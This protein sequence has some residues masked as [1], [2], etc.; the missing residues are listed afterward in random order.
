VTTSGEGLCWGY[1]G[2]GQTNVPTGK[3]WSSITSG[4][5]HSCGVTTSGEGLCWG[6]NHFGQT[7]VPGGKTWASFTAGL[8]DTCGVTTSGE[9]LCWGYNTDGRANVPT[10]KTWA[11]IT[12]GIDHSCG[13][14]TGGEGLCWGFDGHQDAYGYDYD[15]NGDFTGPNEYYVAAVPPD[16][17]LDVP[18]GKFDAVNAPS[19][20]TAPDAPS[21]SAAPT[22]PTNNAS[23]SFTITGEANATFTCSVDGASYAACTSPLALSDLTDGDHTVLVKQTDEAGNTSTE[24]SKTWTVDTTPP[25]APTVSGAP[26]GSTTAPAANLTFAGEANATF[27]CSVDGADYA[28]CSSPLALS[29]LSTGEHVVLVKQT[30]EAGNTSVATTKTWTIRAGC[31][32]PTIRLAFY[33]SFGHGHYWLSTR[34]LA[35]DARPACQLLTIQVWDSQ[36]KPAD[37]DHLT[38]TPSLQL[39]I[40]KYAS[41]SKFNFGKTFTPRWIRVENKVGTW[42]NWYQLSQGH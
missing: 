29:R 35:G 37:S 11:S 20:T 8:F 17:R 34:A 18:V 41:L 38:D 2:E 9:G 15:K 10:G 31:P 30:D 12:T 25:A 22:S 6:Y 42:S 32:K 26:S 23:A 40:L 39:R 5:E 4:G 28:F 16:G 21:V 1:N 3:T 14:T 24:T 13:V 27:L 7:S 19:D 33:K 36:A